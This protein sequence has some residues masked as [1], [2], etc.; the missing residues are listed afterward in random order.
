LIELL[1]P[2][3]TLCMMESS[4]ILAHLE[5]RRTFWNICFHTIFGELLIFR[6]TWV[7]GNSGI[8]PRC[9]KS[10]AFSEIFGKV[11][12]IYIYCADTVCDF[13]FLN[14]PQDCFLTEAKKAGFM[15]QVL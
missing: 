7:N 12:S 3:E 11:L 14:L 13:L 6:E 9:L 8:L 4:G 5:K 1:N 2:F 10:W 15:K